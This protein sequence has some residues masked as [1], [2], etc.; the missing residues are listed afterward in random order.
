MNAQQRAIAVGGRRGVA[1]YV[2][3]TYEIMSGDNFKLTRDTEERIKAV[4]RTYHPRENEHYREI[5][6]EYRRYAEELKTALAECRERYARSGRPYKR[7]RADN[8]RTP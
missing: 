2:A 7:R 5:S 8:R 6:D 4:Y 1:G 3:G